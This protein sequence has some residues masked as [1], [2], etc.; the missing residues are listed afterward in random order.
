MKTLVLDVEAIP[1][2]DPATVAHLAARREQTPETF[3][4]LCPALARPVVVAMFA[5]DS[6]KACAIYDRVACGPAAA[7][8]GN[9]IGADDEA[10]LLRAT[11]D[12]IVRSGAQRLVT[13][14][15]RAYDVPLLLLR[16]LAHTV[17]SAPIL[18]K[19]AFAKPWENDTHVDLLNALTFGGATGRYSLEAYCRAFGVD[20]PKAHGDGS[21]VAQLVTE[22]RADDLIDYCTADVRA[23]ARLLEVW[24]AL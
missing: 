1:A 5:V 18:K 15:G 22:R 21:A 19:I 23:T 13:F 4:A 7:E 20:N 11:H 6:A 9:L 12:L 2:I 10:Q 24:Q 3:C 17:P 14:N 8:G 16:S